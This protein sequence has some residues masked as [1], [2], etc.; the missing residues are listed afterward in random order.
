MTPRLVQ[1]KTKLD[2]LLKKRVKLLSALS[3]VTG[4]FVLQQILRL[5]TNVV[6]AWLLAPELLG[7]MVLINVLR[8]G[9]ELLTDVGIGQSIVKHAEGAEPRFYCTAWT[10]QIARGFVLFLA[11]WAATPPISDLY[12]NPQLGLLLPMCA[13]VFIITGFSSP[14]AFL[15]QKGMDLRK[16][17]M[18]STWVAV[19]SSAA[20]IALALY[21]PTIWALIGGMMISSVFSVLGSFFLL[22]LRLSL[23]LDPNARRE[24]FSFGKWIL[25]SSVIY[26]AAMN[27]DRL[28]LADAVPLAVLGVYGIARTFSDALTSLFARIAALVVFPKISAAGM[29]AA[30]LRASI[31]PVRRVA[32]VI[33][34]IGLASAVSL[35]DQL[36][37][38]IYDQRYEDA[39]VFL[40]I[41]LVGVWFSVLSSLSD[42]ILLGIGKPSSV[43]FANS[44][45]LLFVVLTVPPVLARGGLIPAVCLFSFAEAVRYG[46]LL[47][48]K[49]AYG[50][51]FVR[52]DVST[53][54]MFFAASVILRELTALFGLS[55][56]LSSWA[57][58]F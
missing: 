38:S 34:A 53:T 6:L 15:L 40:P 13:A 42:A 24:I 4:A 23:R 47:W 25:L 45:K 28:Y 36:I 33:L 35:A 12:G 7:T 22:D 19:S 46:V 52:Q 3:W 26:F 58:P 50:L 9:A 2:P 41:L 27:F 39:A 51:A 43:A 44:A 57:A 14:A 29:N 11:L 16:L 8:T 49:R 54:M 31:L 37:L 5:G 10:I 17:A 48:R 56:G 32:L 18:F 55:G 21:T 1:W 30:N 20:H